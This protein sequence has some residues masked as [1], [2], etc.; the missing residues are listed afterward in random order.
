MASAKIVFLFV[1]LSDIIVD[2]IFEVS[3]DKDI[4]SPIL[5]V[6]DIIDDSISILH[7]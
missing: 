2:S 6:S 7:K 3:V 4:V 5:T 1:A